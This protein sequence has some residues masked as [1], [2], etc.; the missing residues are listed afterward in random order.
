VTKDKNRL[1]RVVTDILSPT[2][3]FTFKLLNILRLVLVAF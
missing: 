2:S 1:S 3:I